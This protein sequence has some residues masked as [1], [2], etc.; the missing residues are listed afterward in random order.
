MWGERI[1]PNL[2]TAEVSRFGFFGDL[3]ASV[4]VPSEVLNPVPVVTGLV[5]KV[6][7]L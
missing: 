5:N 6:L 7:M 2:D 4:G 3:L 1:E